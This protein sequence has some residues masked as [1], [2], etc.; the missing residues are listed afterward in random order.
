[1]NRFLQLGLGVVTAIGGFVD[2][3]NLVTS[4]ITGARFG[5]SLTWA[6]VLGTIGMTVYG[7]MAGRVSAVGGRAVFHAVRER[8]GVR[9]ALVNMVASGLLNLLTL[10]AELGGVALVLQL[11]T[12]INYLIW[13]PLV[14]AAMWLVIW[15]LPFSWLEN[16]FG[17]LG[18]ALIVFVVALF[19]LPTDWPGLWHQASHPWVPAGEGHPTYFFY[20]VSLFGACLVPYQVMFFS[21][22]G[23]E[24]KW[25]TDSIPD[26]RM[27]A[28]IGFPLGGLLSIAIMAAAVPVLEPRGI[29]V[30][31]LG[32]VA[33]PVA[34]ALGVTGL[35]FAMLGFFAATFAA[36]AECA[37]STGYMVSQYFGWNWGKMHRPATAPRFHTICLASVIAATAFILTSVDP[38][39]VTL[40]SVVL[41][42]AAIPLTY[43][44]VLVVAND[45][46]YM[47]D[48]VNRALSNTLGVAF[49]VIM[50]VVSIATLP[51]LFITKAG[52]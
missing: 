30:N 38:I 35:A 12:G 25:T 5:A 15:R 41:G 28:I 42:A 39:T 37:L 48:R 49:L 16:L 18:L 4:G 23:R 51:L 9:T 36:G 6:I 20:A 1:V 34:Q 17:L 32:Q 14:A 10:A 22:G 19:K 31:H 52:L 11:V 33:L 45:R 29:N 27:N 26:M 24:E 40:I 44:P 47:G 3:G 43:F 46:E 7:E 21:S 50:V 13:V 8:L 2:I